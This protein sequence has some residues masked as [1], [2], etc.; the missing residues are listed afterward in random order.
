MLA[1][2][3]LPSE[4][5]LSEPRGSSRSTTLGFAPEGRRDAPTRAIPVAEKQLEQNDFDGST[6]QKCA[7]GANSIP[8]RGLAGDPTCK[9]PHDVKPDEDDSDA[10]WTM[11][12]FAFITWTTPS[13]MA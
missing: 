5:E 6:F 13:G 8:A 11:A 1:D 10:R 4:D 3:E 2:E 12:D 7:C 9:F